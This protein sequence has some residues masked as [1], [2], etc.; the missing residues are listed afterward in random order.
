MTMHRI[1]AGILAILIFAEFCSA[2]TFSKKTLNAV[3]TDSPPIIDGIASDEC[4]RTTPPLATADAMAKIEIEIRAAYTEQEIFLLVK[5]PDK[6]E[7]REHRTLIWDKT[8]NLYLGG[9]QREDV[10]VFKWSMEF[11]PIDLTLSSDDEYKADIWYWKAGRTDPTGYADDKFQI[12]SINNSAESKQIISKTGR[13]HYLS[14]NGDQGS[15]AYKIEVLRQYAGNQMPQFS[16]REP[17]ESRGDIKA[18]GIWNNGFWT[19]EFQRKLDTGNPDDIQFIP[20]QQY[21]FGVSRFEIAGREPEENSQEPL[22][23]S[24]EITEHLWLTFKK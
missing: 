14:R 11:L 15:A 3:F 20:T 7:N 22:F 18:K 5:F 2:Q 19:I 1:T 21:L 9:P 13:P 23:G 17:K 12:F 4:W 6:T 24:G 10:F 8:A 16:H